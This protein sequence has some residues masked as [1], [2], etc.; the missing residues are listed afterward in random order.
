MGYAVT[1]GGGYVVMARPRSR[2][3][4]CWRNGVRRREPG[5]EE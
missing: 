5:G 3:P 4:G 1:F 2:I